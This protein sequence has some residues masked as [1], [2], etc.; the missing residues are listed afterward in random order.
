[1]GQQVGVAIVVVVAFGAGFW[2]GHSRGQRSVDTSG[3]EGALRLQET[4]ALAHRAAQDARMSRLEDRLDRWTARAENSSADSESAAEHSSLAP[5]ATGDSTPAPVEISLEDALVIGPVDARATLV[6]F[7]DFQCPHC[8]SLYTTLGRLARAWPKDVRLVFKHFPLASH[9]QALDA[10]IAAQ[11]AAEQGKFHAYAGILFGRQLLDRA[12]L[13]EYAAA[14]ELNLEQFDDDIDSE[15]V[16]ARVREDIEEGQ[17]LRVDRVPTVFFNGRAV[18][19][20]RPYEF[21]VDLL[22]SDAR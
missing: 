12:H 7:S 1:M 14:I 18:G 15:E 16:A 2:V 6:T 11:A 9:P 10:H 21:F 13:R 20:E 3:L 8:A 5:P 17:L 4:E 22:E 19:G